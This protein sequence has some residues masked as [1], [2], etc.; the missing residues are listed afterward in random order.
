MRTRS[1]K[2]FLSILIVLLCSP[3]FAQ[4]PDTAALDA[5]MEQALKHWQTPGAAAVVVRDGQVVYLKGFGLRDI[6][7]KEPVTPDTVF[8]IGSTTKAFTTA[9]MAMLVDEGKMRWDDPVRTHLPAF[10]LADPLASE[11][12]TLRDLVTHRTGLSR[13]DLLWAG[14]PWG[15]AEI[16]RRIG[17]VPLTESFRSIF[18]YQNIMYLA[19]GEAVAAASGSSYEDFIRRRIIDPLGMKSASLSV[20]D[21][22]KAVDHATPYAKR[23]EKIE[24]MSWR[25][26]DNIGPAGSINASVR[27][28]SAWIQLQLGD[29]TYQGKRLISANNLREMH[30]PQ[31][32]IRLE[33]RWRL[34]FPETVTSQLNYGL[35]WFIS[36]YR[37]QH[38][39]MHGGTIDGFRASIM[40]APK[41]GIG[42]A[43]LANLNATQMP[44]ATCYNLLDSLLG[45]PPTDWNAY[46]GERAK[47]FEAEQVTAFTKRYAARKP[48]TTPSL[49]LAAYAGNY[50]EPAYGRATVS[51]EGTQLV[52]QWNAAKSKLE[53]FHFDT[54][55]A[56]EE[57]LATEFVQFQ[58]GPDGEVESMK[59]LTMT[60]RK[61]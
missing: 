29:G 34:F 49:P 20:V 35:G 33:G 39:V 56:R 60:F 26:L 8:A 57:R 48:N 42:I 2:I 5:I 15:R 55:L 12:V 44:E 30:L 54:F 52:I 27:D 19:A 9:A 14:S 40:L 18:Q 23:R 21:A 13:H 59:F 1:N 4:G 7:S 41:K 38:V 25:N 53:H 45:L 50:D 17:L 47:S 51:V 22:Q 37:G 43:V 24:A 31:M 11:Y 46:I 32:A 58:L 3:I 16:L 6:N 61:K 28:L 10:R 36:D